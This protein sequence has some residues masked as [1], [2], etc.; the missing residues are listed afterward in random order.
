[1]DVFLTVVLDVFFTVILGVFVAVVLDVFFTVVLDVL[2][3]SELI[4]SSYSQYY[5]L[6]GTENNFT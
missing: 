3:R 1:M 5:C 4:I 2:L 6:T